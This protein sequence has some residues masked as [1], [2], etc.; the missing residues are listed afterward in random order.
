[1]SL[2]LE[3]SCRCRDQCSSFLCYGPA[4]HFPTCLKAPNTLEL[5]L[6]LPEDWALPKNKDVFFLSVLCPEP[7]TCSSLE[8]Q[9]QET[10]QKEAR[11]HKDIHGA[12]IQAGRGPRPTL[13]LTAHDISETFHPLGSRE[14]VVKDKDEWALFQ[15]TFNTKCLQI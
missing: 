12:G 1:M 13:L 14:L 2:L 3:A 15:D 5:L 7:S 9:S 4:E 11:G 6:Y 8:A 10:W